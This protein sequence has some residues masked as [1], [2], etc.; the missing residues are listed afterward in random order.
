MS[1]RRLLTC[2]L[3]C[4][5]AVAVQAQVADESQWQEAEVPA[6]PPGWRLDRLLR[7][8]GPPQSAL[9]YAIDPQTIRIS[10]S[11]RVVRY[12]FVASSPSGVRNVFYEGI[13]CATAQVRTYAR[14][15]GQAWVMLNDS[16]WAPM[17]SR[18]SRHALYLARQG[19]CD[20]AGT[21]VRAA[22]VIRAL[23]R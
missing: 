15:D 22:D 23:Q 18:P 11:D 7:F 1:H 17:A 2:L 14:H 5:G 19:A 21:P 16:A 6:P 8:E 9:S 3:M 20:N 4:L 13:R 10:P 12:V